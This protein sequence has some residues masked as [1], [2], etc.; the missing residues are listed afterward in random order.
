[1]TADTTKNGTNVTI[2]KKESAFSSNT[3][4]SIKKD[5]YALKR[6]F[7][8][9]TRLT[10]QH[11][12][13]K[14]AL[15]FDLHPDIP[16]TSKTRIADVATGNGI[17]LLDLARKLSGTSKLDGFDI[18]L[19]QCPPQAW[20]PDNVDLHTWNIFEEPPSEF[21]GVFDVVHIRLITVAVRNNNPRP[22][23][24]SLHRLL[25]PGGYIQWDEADSVNWSVKS[26]HH[27]VETKAVRDLFQ[28]LCGT[29]DWKQNM[30]QT[31]NQSGFHN[32]FLHRVEYSKSMARLWSDV[33]M[34]TW[35][36]FAK[37][38]LNAPEDSQDLSTHA[39]DQIRD[40][41]AICCPKLV[42]VAQKVRENLPVQ[43]VDAGLL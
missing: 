17:W 20:L 2:E 9:S 10:A 13:W 1:M 28:Q 21:V 34:S 6:D 26:V 43:A 18:S 4:A 27:S 35:D 42:W 23:L 29:H 36:E 19:D 11:Y 15:N 31:I 24:A 8:A 41:S 37:V 14:D 25:K 16:I 32:T 38:V 30:V 33:Y 3:Y 39:M 12:L 22:I 7:N 5:T 40:G